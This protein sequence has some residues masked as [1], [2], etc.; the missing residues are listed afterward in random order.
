MKYGYLI[1]VTC[2]SLGLATV[3]YVVSSSSASLEADLSVQ[4][5][6]A[7]R[8]VGQTEQ[9][10]V[11]RLWEGPN[12]NFWSADI[13]PDGRFMTELASDGGGLKF[14]DLHERTFKQLA[15][16]GPWSGGWYGWAVFSP[17]ADRI[18]Y[19]GQGR[20]RVF[21]IRTAALDGS[22]ERTIYRGANQYSSGFVDGW[23]A[24]GEWLVARLWDSEA[25]RVSLLSAEDG[26]ERPV[27][28]PAEVDNVDLSPDGRHLAFAA[29]ARQGEMERDVF[30]VPVEGGART[31][32]VDGPADDRL[33]GWAPDGSGVLLSRNGTSGQGFWWL[34]VADGS[35]VGAPR[36]V[37]SDVWRPRPIGFSDDGRFFYGVMTR[38]PGV[39][40]A[41]IDLDASRLTTPPVEAEDEPELRSRWPTWSPDGRYLAYRK[42]VPDLPQEEVIVRSATGGTRQS[43]LFDGTIL[44][45]EWSAE[46]DRLVIDGTKNNDDEERS[47]YTIDLASGETTL[48][49]RR[50]KGLPAGRL[51][52]DGRT[53]FFPN[54]WKDPDDTSIT[55][56]D[57]E[58][59]TER[60]LA[61]I[62]GGG[63]HRMSRDGQRFALFFQDPE[64]A[65]KHLMVYTVADGTLREVLPLDDAERGLTLDWTGDDGTILFSTVSDDPSLRGLWQ[66]PAAGGERRRVE[67]VP[68]IRG[69]FSIHPDGNRIAFFSGEPRGEVWVLE[70]LDVGVR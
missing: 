28:Q 67:G 68:E 55:L 60:V 33:M 44:Q 38:A 66:V 9:L 26:T 29:A 2:L 22:D 57:L 27:F 31:S 39:H 65:S 10:V 56:M 61:G 34:T 62:V 64:T 63:N 51:Q 4:L 12:P 69:R 3:L 20:G 5:D 7:G 46:G 19:N 48:Y 18:A 41:G 24:D 8:E 49:R 37:K 13:S 11:R 1:A 21:E 42:D 53:Y 50:P 23:S 59:G 17:G 32:L 40:I 52:R 45:L 35:P 15:E 14:L 70:G 58:T 6:G 54:N 30:S 36:L 43:I 16:Q 47:I 25:G